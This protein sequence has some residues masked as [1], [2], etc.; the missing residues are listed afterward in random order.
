MKYIGEVD[1]G[2]NVPIEINFT[3]DSNSPVIPIS[4]NWTLTDG[5]FNIINGRDKVAISISG[6]TEYIIL[7]EVDTD[8]DLDSSRFLIIETAY[9]SAYV[10]TPISKKTV[11]KFSISDL[12]G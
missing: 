5:D 10:E 2:E 11:L 1:E 3:D 12:P 9:N 7:S 6:T 4:S 8:Y